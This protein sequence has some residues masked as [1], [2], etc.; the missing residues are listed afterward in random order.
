MIVDPKY[1][2]KY[3][4]SM[5]FSSNFSVWSQLNH[6]EK[7]AWNEAPYSTV[8]QKEIFLKLYQDKA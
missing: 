3:D 8:E 6:E 7:I 1:K 4:D 5:S 2:F